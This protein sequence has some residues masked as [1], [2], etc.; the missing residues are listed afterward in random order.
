MPAMTARMRIVI[1]SRG[2]FVRWAMLECAA[3]AVFPFQLRVAGQNRV[4][5][6]F[7]ELA[8]AAAFPVLQQQGVNPT[9]DG[10][11]EGLRESGDRWPRIRFRVGRSLGTRRCFAKRGL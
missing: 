8:R 2:S 1:E 10:D 7:P 4:P 11:R 6:P 9:R 5:D 3:T